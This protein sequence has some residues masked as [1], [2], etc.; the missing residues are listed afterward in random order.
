MIKNWRSTVDD[1]PTWGGDC[2]AE[3][4][5]MAE[6]LRGGLSLCSSGFGFFSHDIGGFEAKA[7]PD[8]Y[9]RWCLFTLSSVHWAASLTLTSSFQ[10]SS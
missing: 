6:T 9:K 10:A 4:T 7:S 2:S 5:S 1:Y 3:Y 8:V